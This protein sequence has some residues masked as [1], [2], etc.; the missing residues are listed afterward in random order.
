MR[1]YPTRKSYQYHGKSCMSGKCWN[2]Q[3]FYD[4]FH[5]AG[6]PER[7]K[8]Y[9]RNFPRKD[10]RLEQGESCTLSKDSIR[11]VAN[12]SYI[13]EYLQ[14][15][16]SLSKIFHNE[17]G[18]YVEMKVVRTGEE[19]TVFGFTDKTNEI[20]E[21]NDKIYKKCW[22]PDLNRCVPKQKK[23]NCKIT[24]SDTLSKFVKSKFVIAA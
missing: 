6:T 14:V 8:R 20:T 16:S 3:E 10:S 9:F 11:N 7:H 12:E 17:L 2:H 21:I 23:S 18:H 4:S 5:I 19:T 13:K 22:E 1:Q 15:G 24:F